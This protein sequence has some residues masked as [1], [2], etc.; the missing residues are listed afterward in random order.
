M[1]VLL[2]GASGF[3]GLNVVEA[4]LEEKYTVHVFLR[5]TSNLTYLKKFPVVYH[6]GELNDPDA[7]INAMKDIDYVI[8]IAGNTSSL[9]KDYPLLYQTNVIGTKNIVEGALRSNVKRLV[10]TSTTATVGANDGLD[11]LANESTPIHG[12]RQQNLYSQ[13]KLEAEDILHKARGL[14]LDSIILNPAEIIGAYDHNFQWGRMVL[15]VGKKE[16]LFYPPG[17]ASFC[18]A[19]SVAKAHV[20]ALTS[21]K[22]G[23]RYILAGENVS[24]VSLINTIEVV[25]Q[26]SAKI[27]PINFKL[28]RFIFTLQQLISP[29]SNKPPLVDSYRMKVFAGHYLFSSKKAAR[30]LSYQSDNL[31]RMITECYQWYLKNGFL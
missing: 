19:K 27:V 15:A 14:G 31:E 20:T 23:E 22:V 17:S 8:H 9:K 28:L 3:V 2:T 4:L 25:L 13:T 7:I 21:G 1:N 30:D 11:E 5:K 18:S 24:F 16:A 29:I 10:Y 6:Y 12:F 26:K